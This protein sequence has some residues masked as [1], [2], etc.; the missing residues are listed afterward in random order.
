MK[1]I[2]SIALFITL[3]PVAAN[4]AQW[5]VPQDAFKDNPSGLNIVDSFFNT[6][7]SISRIEIT[8]T[9]FN[10]TNYV[11]RLCEQM[12]TAPCDGSLKN[13]QIMLNEVLPPCSAQIVEWCIEGLSIYNKDNT[14]KDASLIRSTAGPILKKHL[15]S[16]MPQGGT[17]SLWK[18][19]GQI[20]SGGADT[21]A[22][23]LYLMGNAQGSG[24]FSFNSLRAMV[25][26]Y[27]EIRGNQYVDGSVQPFDDPKGKKQ[28]GVSGG[29]LECAWTEKGVCGYIEDFPVNSRVNL[30][31]RVG[32]NLSG[33][34]MGRMADPR[35]TVSQVSATQNLMSIDSEP[36]DVPKFFVSVPRNALTPEISSIDPSIKDGIMSLH[37]QLAS[38]TDFAL[39]TAWAK[40]TD[41]KAAGKYSVW[42]LM[43]TANGQGSNCL[44]STTKVVGIV[45]T[46][47]AIYEGN[48]PN[49]QDGALMYR[50][51]S[52]HYAADGSVFKG[53]YDLVMRSEAAR[54]LY[55]FSAAPISAS[56]SIT[57]NDG[58][59]Q[60]ATTVL[61]ESNGWLHL[62]ADGFTFSNP[63]IKVTLKQ[64]KN[65]PS[66]ALQNQQ[67]ICIKGKLKKTVKGTSPKCP[68]GYKKA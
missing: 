57:S 44:R 68:T 8:D 4:G 31:I 52:Q 53:K 48:A 5:K 13:S 34:M 23:Y 60:V 51:W 11:H 7:E 46:N 1:K 2:L 25:L 33:W 42:S 49:F 19:P 54:C 6:G 40:F 22:V 3:I 41:D 27:S 14:A 56:I 29:Q 37:N 47:A 9:S 17:V 38:Q 62:G 67:I 32:N 50:V 21:Y 12:G 26:P 16:G 28:I 24:D 10:S 43:S 30:R 65:P 15:S 18:A 58:T 64:S 59:S 55:G 66:T 63:T 61:N 20:N 36:I 39:A 35:V 45:T